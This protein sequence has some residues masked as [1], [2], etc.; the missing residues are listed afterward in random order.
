[1]Y[2]DLALSYLKLDNL[3]VANDWD[4]HHKDGFVA[5]FPSQN[6]KYSPHDSSEACDSACKAEPECS[7]WTYHL[8]KCRFVT[9]RRYGR[10]REP[11]LG[12]ETN[13]ASAE[14]AVWVPDLDGLRFVAGWDTAKIQAWIAARPCDQVEWVTASTERIF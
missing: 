3:T 2:R 6:Y 8:R 13:A 4:N 10:H 12:T 1:M 7:Q 14:D 5:P 9:T 11:E